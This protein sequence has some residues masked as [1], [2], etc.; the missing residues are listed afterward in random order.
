ML[1]RRFAPGAP[2]PRLHLQGTVLPGGEVRDL[3]VADGLIR[4]TPV[5]EATTICRNAY[6]MPGFVDAHCHVGL[7]SHGAVPR[8]E[9]EA[10]AL[11]DRDAGALLLRDCGQPGDTRWMD[12]VEDLPQMVRAGRHI[13]RPRRYI[14]GYAAEIEPD[15][16]VAE[17]ERQAA[18][19][20]GWIK[21]VGDWIDRA[22]GDLAPL[23]PAEQVTA[24]IAR[25]HELGCRVTA[26]HFGEEGL[27]TYIQ[28]GI[29]G[30]EHG[31]G[32]TEKT[33][34]LMAERDVALVPTMVNLENF[35]G[36]AAA[37]EEKFPDYAA[38]MRALYARRRET[39]GACLDAGVRI[40]AGTDAGGTV[41]HGLIGQELAL[42]GEIGGAEFALGAGSWRAREW[43]GHSGI[44]DGA[45]ADL[46]VF[47]AD[48]R[49]DLGILR[50]PLRVILRG[51]VVL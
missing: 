20:D 44:A 45:P 10:Q 38:H 34:A 23:W 25:A 28:A 43:L 16:L 35:P 3:W 30:I 11:I 47:Q 7:D 31:T 27:E 40:Y 17:V 33:I 41:P 14:R 15:D 32:L 1:H 2:K 24:A 9:T 49:T 22:T 12:Q 21:L 39:F 4:L 6:L 50:A 29:D 42:L 13:A 37:G 19:G 51:Q 36:I 26:H 5:A 48:P 18:R 46:V 8:E